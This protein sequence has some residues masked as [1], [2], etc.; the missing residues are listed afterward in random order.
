MQDKF[1]EENQEF[2]FECVK[3]VMPRRHSICN[4]RYES[5]VQERAGLEFDIW[6]LLGYEWC[7]NRVI[8]YLQVASLHLLNSTGQY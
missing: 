7:L 5:G 8:S 1:R 4:W 6:E 2:S 3:S